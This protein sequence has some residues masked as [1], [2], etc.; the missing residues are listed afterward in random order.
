ME[1][2]KGFD[3]VTIL[4]VLGI[5]LLVIIMV[6]PPIL[7]VLDESE[8]AVPTP[9]PE[10]KEALTIENLNSISNNGIVD[11]TNTGIV[12]TIYYKDG[13][14]YQVKEAITY[15]RVTDSDIDK[16]N[17]KIELYKDIEGITGLCDYDG[18]KFVETFIYYYNELNE[19]TTDLPIEKNSNIKDVLKKYIEDNNICYMK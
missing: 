4:C 6:L 8:E 18:G 16:C 11:C 3:S 10:V 13:V 1:N 14:I 9:T 19:V 17:Q 5:L 2:K 7:R 15:E 12:M